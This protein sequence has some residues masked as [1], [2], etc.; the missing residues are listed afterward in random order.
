MKTYLSLF[1]ALSS[2]LGAKP[3]ADPKTFKVF[4]LAGQSNMEGKGAVDMD[5]PKEY[6]SLNHL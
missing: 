4:L 5:H 1:L 3:K 2:I 6:L